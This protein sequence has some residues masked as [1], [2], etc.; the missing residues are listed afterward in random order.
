MADPVLRELIREIIEHGNPDIEEYIW[1]ALSSG[2]CW[3]IIATP[4]IA[5]P[6]LMKKSGESAGDFHALFED[7]LEE[8]QLKKDFKYFLLA[9]VLYYNGSETYHIN[10]MRVDLDAIEAWGRYQPDPLS[11]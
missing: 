10:L 11:G 4:Q 3:G 8:K 6:Y 2:S 9:N 5:E 7:F 1:I